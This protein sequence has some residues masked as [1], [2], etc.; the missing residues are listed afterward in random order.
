MLDTERVV[1]WPWLSH[2]ER[3]AFVLVTEVLSDIAAG[4]RRT[5]P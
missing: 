4:S 2:E 3:E 1:Y 5:E